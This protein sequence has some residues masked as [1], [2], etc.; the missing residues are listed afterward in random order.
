MQASNENEELRLCSVCKDFYGSQQTNF[1]CSK[2]HREQNN[3]AKKEQE[4]VKEAAQMAK[5]VSEMSSPLK[6][7][8]S[9]SAPTQSAAVVE[10]VQAAASEEVKELEVAKKEE[11]SEMK[12]ES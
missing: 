6:I 10:P 2:C 1:L 9:P 5:E 3:E 8:N 12:D 7:P 11:N 4:T